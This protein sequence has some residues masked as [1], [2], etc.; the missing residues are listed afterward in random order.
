M[1][2]KPGSIA[3]SV[4]STKD[5]NPARRSLVKWTTCFVQPPYFVGSFSTSGFSTF[6]KSSIGR[7]PDAGVADHEECGVPSTP[8]LSM[9]SRQRSAIAR[10]IFSF[11]EQASNWSLDMPARRP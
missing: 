9:P 2:V 8:Y 10:S 3:S 1:P 6:S 11:F 7:L 5:L 4:A